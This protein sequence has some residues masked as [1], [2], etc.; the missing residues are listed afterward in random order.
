MSTRI[1]FTVPTS[2]CA[3]GRSLGGEPGARL[4]L[5]RIVP[6]D[7]TVMPFFWVWNR[8]PE[9]FAAAARDERAIDEIS[10]V[11]RVEGGTL[12]A[13]R[14][15]HEEA[16][17]LFA[18]ARSEGALLDARATTERWRFEVRFVDRAAA[19]AFRTFCAE[20]GVPLSIERVTTASPRED[21][22]YGLTDE[23]REAL[24]VAYQR[25]YFEEP[26]RATLEDVARE[27]GITPRALA[28]RL[29]RGQ[30]TL[31]ERTDLTALPA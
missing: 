13:A 14:W 12:F 21:D 20:R 4:E 8:D 18:I 2:A 27:I 10:I 28:G 23:Q 3:L 5:D 17:T 19:G 30:A 16:G 26:R 22:R 29:R 31:L 24:A 1:E 11:E 25:G 7:D 9:L 15:N 6:T